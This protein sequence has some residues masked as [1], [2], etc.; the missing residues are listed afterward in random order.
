M[1][2]GNDKIKITADINLEYEVT[3][4]FIKKSESDVIIE[5]FIY[6][7]LKNDEKK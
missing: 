3:D 6:S 5:E 1:S 4:E 2:F 7:I